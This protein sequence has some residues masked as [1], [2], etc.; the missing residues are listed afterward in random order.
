MGVWKVECR[1]CGGKIIRQ[2]KCIRKD[3]TCENGHSYHWSPYH[4]EYH[5]GISDHSKDS[6]SPNCCVEN[7]KC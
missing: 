6:N 2:C 4:N 3:Q 7:K 1:I 5:E